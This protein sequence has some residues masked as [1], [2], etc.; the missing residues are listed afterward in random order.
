MQ[1]NMLGMR[2]RTLAG[3]LALGLG[4]IFIY[5][6][7]VKIIDPQGFT[8]ALYGYRLLPAWTLPAFAIL[9][10]WWELGAGLAVLFPCWRKAGL[11]LT[12]ILS[13]IFLAA[14]VS[15]WWRGLD[16]GCGCFGN[17]S[18]KPGLWAT[19]LDISLFSAS[20]FL[21]RLSQ[22][23]IEPSPIPNSQ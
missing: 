22:P 6:G 20:L 10:P 7:I 8:K 5:A 9:L 2:E 13:L 1:N 19:L 3:F 4:G 14:V 21:F 15:A 18:T 23:R 17:S 11:T 16:I 12:A